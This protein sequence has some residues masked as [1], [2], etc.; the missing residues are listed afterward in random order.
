MLSWSYKKAIKC[1]F[2]L[3]HKHTENHD[4]YLHVQFYNMKKVK[5]IKE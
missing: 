2:K 5:E 3:Y 1:T 4:H